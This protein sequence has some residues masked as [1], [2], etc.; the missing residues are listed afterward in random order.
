MSEIDEPD[1]G[2]LEKVVPRVTVEMNEAFPRP[3]MAEEVKRALFSIGDLKAPEWE[4]Q[5]GS[6]MVSTEGP[7]TV[8]PVWS[9]IWKLK[10][11]SKIKIYMWRALRGVILGMGVLAHRHIK[12]S[13]Q[14]PICREWV[15]DI[16]HLL[17]TCSRARKVWKALGLMDE[18][19]KSLLVDRSGSVVLEEILRW[20]V[21]RSPILGHLG[22]Q[23]VVTVGAWYIWWE[24]REAKKGA[25]VKNPISS[26]FSI[27]AI[28][29]NHIGQIPENITF[30][31]RW[32]KQ[33]PG[34][35]K[36]NTDAS[37]FEDGS[38]AITAII[39][40]SRGH[41]VAGATEL[42]AHAHDVASA[43]VLAL[44]RGLLLAVR[45]TAQG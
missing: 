14:C 39:R 31:E 1:P 29:S 10:V 17:F 24:R 8:N 28:A 37:F 34:S 41:A 9:I 30:S 40:D 25:T 5:F 13:P 43:E 7:P 15:A 22:L 18:I 35:Y 21:Q 19:E 12:V 20:P 4:H 36:V 2:L 6:R 23:E 26:A 3:Y 16:R 44:R 27:H 32:V 42:F 33:T 38:G 45:K 11:P